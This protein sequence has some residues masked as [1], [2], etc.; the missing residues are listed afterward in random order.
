MTKEV[1]PYLYACLILSLANLI[2]HYQI[3]ISITDA[4]YNAA[5]WTGILGT[6]M[7][8]L[9]FPLILFLPISAIRFL[10]FKEKKWTNLR[11]ISLLIGIAFTLLS[12]YGTYLENRV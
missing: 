5:H 2:I 4:N 11:I 3:E 12:I 6:A 7:P 8:I 1:K 10:Y 9:L